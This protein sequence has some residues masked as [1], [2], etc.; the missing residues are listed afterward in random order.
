MRSRATASSSRIVLAAA[1]FAL[2]GVNG[3]TL[4]AAQEEEAPTAEPRVPSVTP[5]TAL[6][7]HLRSGVV[8]VSV[9]GQEWNWQTPWAKQPPWTR[10]ITRNLL[11]FMSSTVCNKRFVYQ[12]SGESSA[13][14]AS[15]WACFP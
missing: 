4:L 12:D 14:C 1:F 2:L 8:Q 10:P 13:A 5:S 7:G 11:T 3:E 9:S 15:R 6:N